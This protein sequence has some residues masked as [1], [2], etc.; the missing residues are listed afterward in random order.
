MIRY[1]LLWLGAFVFTSAIDAI[2]HL[3]LFGRLYKEGMRPLARMADG[4]FAFKVA[5]ALLSQVLVVTAVLL[6]VLL[7]SEGAP[8]AT[9]ALVGALAGVLA[10]SVYGVTNYALLKDW[11]LGITILETIWGPM[12]G[13]CSGAFAY[14]L[15]SLLVR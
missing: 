11:G 12:I 1:A 2:W 4:K 14:W 7:K 10:I 6:L 13:A 3:A 15:K 8:L 5:A 9:A